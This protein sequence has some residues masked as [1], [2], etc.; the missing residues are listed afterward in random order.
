VT[1]PADIDAAPG[2]ADGRRPVVLVTGLSG[3]G[4]STALKALE[5]LGYEAVDNLP[6]DLLDPLVDE[7]RDT[8]PVAV[9]IDIRTRDFAAGPFLENLDKLTGRPELR[10][11]L[12]FLDC[13][14]EVLERRF[15]ETRRRHPLAQDRRIADGIA[16]ERRLV[17]P[18]RARAAV[19]LDTSHLSPGELRRV[20]A[21][22]LGLG[23]GP[24]MAVFLTSFSYRHGLP[25]EADLVFDV[26]FL[27]NPHYEPDL[28]A[29]D[30]RARQVAAF[31]EGDDAFQGFFA[32]LT[33]MLAPLLPR[34]EQEGKSY[35][36]IAF[37]CT[38]GRHRSVV[39]AEK[40]A[41]W[42]AARGRSVQ[43][44]HRDIARAGAAPGEEA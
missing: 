19:V 2:H 33:E 42:F 4:R 17:A 43:T 26:R 15:T 28:R 34:Y 6:L 32:R 37:G 36:T 10:V 38:G 14:D 44:S 8:R 27:K 11:A 22:H 20:L 12:L 31:V 1:P 7:E 29:H 30:G 18:L 16:H 40:L 41:G 21:G 13:D 23:R 25:R 3:A 24:G 35:L 9:G 5:D 39:V